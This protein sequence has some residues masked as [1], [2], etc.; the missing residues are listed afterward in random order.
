MFFSP[1]KGGGACGPSNPFFC[2]FS[3]W[4]FFVCFAWP[5][6]KHGFPLALLG[7]PGLPSL[8]RRLFPVFVLSLV[9][10]RGDELVTSWDSLFVDRPS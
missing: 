5:A 7:L 1:G 8:P 2:I 6:M 3:F 9:D 10:F 4:L